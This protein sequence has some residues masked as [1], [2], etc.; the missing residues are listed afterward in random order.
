M[1]S[2]SSVELSQKYQP[3]KLN[4]GGSSIDRFFALLP[5]KEKLA[6]CYIAMP[7]THRHPPVT[8]SGK[9]SEGK[10]RWFSSLSAELKVHVLLRRIG[11]KR[12]LN[13]YTSTCFN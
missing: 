1:S 7:L 4:L 10:T 2:S 5:Q 3:S 8:F 13:E 9:P 11:T 12:S 6:I